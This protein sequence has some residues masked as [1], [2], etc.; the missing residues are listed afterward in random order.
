MDRPRHLGPPEE[1][2]DVGP[3]IEELELQL[4]TWQ[5]VL[6]TF[7]SKGWA[8]VEATLRRWLIEANND[9]R[10]PSADTM[11]RVSFLRGR[12]AAYEQV[13]SLRRDTDRNIEMLREQL[14]E[15]MR[16]EDEVTASGD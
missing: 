13:L 5:E 3:S 16:E 1:P 15:R 8:H 6:E 11:E 7:A 2:E 14:R 9:L 4:Q 10:N 12:M